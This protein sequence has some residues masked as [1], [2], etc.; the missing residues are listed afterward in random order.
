MQFRFLL[1]LGLSAGCVSTKSLQLDHAETERILTKI[2]RNKALDCAP[3]IFASA[4]AH[5]EFARLE[6][7]QGDARLALLHVQQA[8]A[9]ARQL[10]TRLLDDDGGSITTTAGTSGSTSSSKGT[11]RKRTALVE[12]SSNANLDE[13]EKYDQIDE[14]T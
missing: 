8:L 4:E 5:E 9:D 1:I 13:D 11:I 12:K 7:K 3:E 2:D 14:I 10:S 6:F